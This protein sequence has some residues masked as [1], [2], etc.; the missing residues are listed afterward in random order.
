MENLGAGLS[1]AVTCGGSGACN[2]LEA[3]SSSTLSAFTAPTILLS[4]LV[5]GSPDRPAAS[6]PTR[7]VPSGHAVVALR[8]A[9]AVPF[10][11]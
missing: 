11:A 1:G 8:G 2:A 6:A 9:T 10:P 4:V 3:T 5:A 7:S